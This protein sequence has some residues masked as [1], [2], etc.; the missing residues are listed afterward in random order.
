MA[1]NPSDPMWRYPLL[2]LVAGAMFLTLL[3]LYFRHLW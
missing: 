1:Y 2:W 3:L